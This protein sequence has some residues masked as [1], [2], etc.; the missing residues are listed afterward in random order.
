M[1]GAFSG[2]RKIGG[3][4]KDKFSHCYGVHILLGKRDSKQIKST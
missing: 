1:P 2:A 4:K 3:N